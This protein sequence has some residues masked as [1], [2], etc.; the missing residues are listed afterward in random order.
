[1]KQLCLS[2]EFAVPKHSNKDK[3]DGF[4]KDAEEGSAKPESWYI[5]KLLLPFL[6]ACRL[7]VILHGVAI[8]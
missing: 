1:M 4:F 5:S 8:N 6:W 2:M 7:P 3:H